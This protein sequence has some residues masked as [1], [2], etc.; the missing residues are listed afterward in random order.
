M[1]DWNRVTFEQS[2]RRYRVQ[3]ESALDAC[4]PPA[5]TVPRH[6]HEAMRYAS[7]N[8]GKRVRA[9]L[10][11]ATSQAL[12]VDATNVDSAACAVELIHAY[13]LVHDDLPSMDDDDLRRGKPT[14]HRA[15]GEATAL[16]VG[17]SLQALAFEVLAND[18]QLKVC[19]ERRVQMLKTLAAASGSRGMAGGQALD[20]AAVGKRL[21]LNELEAMHRLKTGALIRA[22]VMLGALASESAEG[23]TLAHLSDY[24]DCIGLAFQIVDDLLDEE[25]DTT[26][27][28][29]TSGADRASHKPTYPVLMGAQA[30]RDQAHDLQHRA[31]KSLTALSHDTRALCELADFIIDRG[32]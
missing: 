12:G 19:A 30:A 11:Y 20:L 9:A 17:D 1:E 31:Q 2:L 6:L 27:L 21:S 32:Y 18:R 25:A 7:L 5:D 3:V 13:S 10:V 26:T 16:L 15:Y 22:S 24:A 29:K 28:G 14:C 8:G 23:A 4:L